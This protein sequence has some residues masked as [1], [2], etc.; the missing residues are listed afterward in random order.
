[1]TSLPKDLVDLGNYTTQKL[2]HYVR[3]LRMFQ[4][5]LEKK[6][7]LAIEKQKIF[8]TKIRNYQ[9]ALQGIDD[10]AVKDAVNEGRLAETRY[11]N[12]RKALEQMKVELDDAEMYVSMA[13]EQI[14]LHK[15]MV[16]D[17]ITN[18]KVMETGQS[19]YLYDNMNAYKELEEEERRGMTAAKLKRNAQLWLHLEEARAA[20]IARAKARVG[21]QV[22]ER[23]RA[24]N[25][26][27]LTK[28]EFLAGDG[29]YKGWYDAYI[30]PGEPGPSSYTGPASSRQPRHNAIMRPEQ[31]AAIS[32]R[33]LPPDLLGPMPPRQGHTARPPRSAEEEALAARVV[34]QSKMSR[35]EKLLSKRGSRTKDRNADGLR[36][37]MM[38]LAKTKK[39]M[40]LK[41]LTKFYNNL[42]KHQSKQRRRKNIRKTKRVGSLF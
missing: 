38:H 5:Q 26:K 32:A 40:K 13:K 16:N 39:T 35:T 42:L 28:S 14:E 20:W 9:I 29:N 25:G 31:K 22:G 27:M 37:N 17:Y 15:A 4:K 24:P 33:R 10:A 34:A 12:A 30:P 36:R 19:V 18:G 21:E 3:T 23:R 8:E 1:M 41:H 11:E 2:E 7:A 6:E